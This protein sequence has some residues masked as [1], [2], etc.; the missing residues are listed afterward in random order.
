MSGNL[1]FSAVLTRIACCVCF[2]MLLLM[3][4]PC[5]HV[6]LLDTVSDVRPLGTMVCE[7]ARIA[8]SSCQCLTA[9]SSAEH[10]TLYPSHA[11]CA[12]FPSLKFPLFHHT[13]FVTRP[14]L[15]IPAEMDFGPQMLGY[16]VSN[17]T[18]PVLGCNIDASGEPALRGKIRQHVV[19]QYG[20]FKV[21]RGS[22]V[23]LV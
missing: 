23:W 13:S 21:G 11:P 2:P 10:D 16:F 12:C 19:L 7:P 8:R 6:L 3:L 15:T 20:K 22:G 9:N 18:F 5:C 1:M 17:L 4:P 14:F